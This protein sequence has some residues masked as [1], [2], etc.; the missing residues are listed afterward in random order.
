MK[1]AVS[2]PNDVFREAERLTRELGKSRSQLYAEALK[3]YLARHDPDSVTA[4]LNDVYDSLDSQLD[5]A[6]AAV[7][8]DVLR[9]R[10]GSIPFSDARSLTRRG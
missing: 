2:I 8:M 9:R 4:A 10:Q 3:E 7:G 1:T 6:L 5:P